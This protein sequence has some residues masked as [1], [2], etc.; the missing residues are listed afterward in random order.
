V[1]CLRRELVAP[2]PESG[3]SSP[4]PYQTDHQPAGSHKDCLK[5]GSQGQGDSVSLHR[6]SHPRCVFDSS[7]SIAAVLLRV[8]SHSVSSL[9]Q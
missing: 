4:F 3:R 8:G 6:F 7:T 5:S 2:S 1:E 9:M